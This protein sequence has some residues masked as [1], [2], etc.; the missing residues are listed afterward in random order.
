MLSLF[1]CGLVLFSVPAAEASSGN[2]PASSMS[3]AAVTELKEAI[4]LLKNYHINRN[5]VDWKIVA[6]KAFAIAS[7]A[8]TAA[9]TYPAI[10]FVI[11]QLG[12]KHTLL[13]TADLIKALQSGHSDDKAMAAAVAQASQ[14]P[15]GLP[16]AG[17]IGYLRV[18][19]LSGSPDSEIAYV[20]ALRAKLSEFQKE[21]ECRFVIDLRG[22]TG[23]DMWPMLNGLVS[24]LGAP[25]YG[26]FEYVN[27]KMPWD[28]TKGYMGMV[29]SGVKPVSAELSAAQSNKPV[30]V[31]INRYTVSAGEFTGIA[32]E[33]RPH[34]RFFGEPSFGDVTFNEAHDLPD[35]ASLAISEGWVSDRLGK[36]YRVALV[37][38]EQTLRGPPTLNAALQWLKTQPCRRAL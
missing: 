12:E 19:A 15:E 36:P 22:N 28:L 8:K 38:D 24:L 26:Y 30:A 3:V 18:P 11:E 13:M 34:V 16:L 20:A 27:G 29:D 37:P 9:D 10:R 1:F 14:K 21:G 25:P 2:D 23:G 33:G 32:F 31:L 6:E 17:R 7:N 35:G 4:G 5:K